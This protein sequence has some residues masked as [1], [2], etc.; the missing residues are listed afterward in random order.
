MELKTASGKVSPD[1]WKIMEALHANGYF[2]RLV[3]SVGVGVE[4]IYNYL[5]EMP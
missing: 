2:V 3:N 5:E 1:Q 4:I